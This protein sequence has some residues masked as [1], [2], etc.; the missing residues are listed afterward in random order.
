M[1]LCVKLILL[2]VIG[3]CAACRQT[4]EVETDSDLFTALIVNAQT[5]NNIEF[6]Y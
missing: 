2:A 1:K 6:L 5:S 4:E 3:I